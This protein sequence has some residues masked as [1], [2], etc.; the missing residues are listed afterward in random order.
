MSS[1]LPALQVI[2][3]LMAAPVCVLLRHHLASRIFALAISWT[4]LCVSWAILGEVQ[5]QGV[6]SYELGGFPPPMGIELRI[7]HGNAF[8]L[9][10]V[11]LI[12]AVVMTLGNAL[13]VA[14]DANLQIAAVA[15]GSGRRLQYVS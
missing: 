12:G 9:M 6:I 4:S 10:I 5:V 8:I 7:D 3:P 11:S 13:D 2:L 1:N 15:T 14:V